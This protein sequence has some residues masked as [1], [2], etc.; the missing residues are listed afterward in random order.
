M[1][2]EIQRYKKLLELYPTN[3]LYCPN[4]FGP[5]FGCQALTKSN[6]FDVN[7]TRYLYIKTFNS[8]PPEDIWSF[9]FGSR[10]ELKIFVEQ[11]HLINVKIGILV[12][13]GQLSTKVIALQV[14]PSDTFDKVFNE[15]KAKGFKCK[16]LVDSTSSFSPSTPI[17]MRETVYA[18]CV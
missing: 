12:T 14:K 6:H 2:L 5:E 1:D 15:I 8:M 9:G 13:D 10:P 11:L 4:A 7:L 18:V 16:L 17:G 3:Q